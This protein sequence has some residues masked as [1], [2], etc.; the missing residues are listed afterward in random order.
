VFLMTF[1]V[2]R[3]QDS[4]NT[5]A[6]AA[7]VIL[8]TDPPSLFSISFQL[9]FAA[10]F[11]IIY[12]FSCLRDRPTE[13]KEQ[14]EDNWPIRFRSKLVSFFLVS[15]FAICGSLP[16]V[17]YYFN[18]ISLVGLAA[19]MIV[20]PLV[21][22]ISIPIGL[23]ALFTMPFNSLFASWCINAGTMVLS[24]AL[25]IVKFFADLPFAAVKIV[26]PG[27]IEIACFY[28]LGW[29][30]LNLYRR[31][32]NETA[33]PQNT[34]AA[35]HIIPGDRDESR[36]TGRSGLRPS[37]EMLAGRKITRFSASSLA[38]ITVVLVLFT[39]AA[40]TCYWLYQRFWHQD[41]RVTVVD[42]GNGAASLLELPGGYTILIDG[43]GFSDNA[44][45]D[46]GERVLAPFL[47]SKKIRTV[48]T[49]IL[50]HPNSDHLNGLIYIADNFHVKNIWTNN[51]PGNTL[52]YAMLMSVVANRGISLPVFEYM[53]RRHQIED[54][55]FDF[56][57]PPSDFLK[58]K[59]SEK[60]R[61]PNN[62]SLVVKVSLGSISFLFPGDIMAEAEGE[63]VRMVGNK[64]TSTV[65]IA[66]HHGS[67]TSSSEIFLDEVNPE[68]VIIS[69]GRNSRFQL[70]HRTVLKRYQERGCT[71]WRTDINGAIRMATDGEH[72]EVKPF[73]R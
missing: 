32:P 55:E 27:F 69:T 38:K 2:Q 43:G 60:W 39:L 33:A 73:V 36:R 59:N 21:G 52:A 18:Q 17:A 30:L 42:V 58:R 15:F 11:A 44:A 54:V 68:V 23:V 56:L 4:L 62:N 65:L 48:D 45:F 29:A 8:A 71:I 19:N 66:P 40:D 3:E 28:M 16:L 64:L 25:G 10:V 70:P 31:R 37:L 53:P 47:W 46:M 67:R 24:F 41:L 20:V 50:S 5:L 61:N 34:G 12:G 9:S 1:I 57:Y 63:I 51:E 14:R 22:F 7:L 6:L 13:P 26:T 49:L 35:D 72:L